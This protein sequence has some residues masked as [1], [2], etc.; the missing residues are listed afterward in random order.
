GVLTVLHNSEGPLPIPSQQVES[1]QRMLGS[2]LVCSLHPY[3]K[4]GD[5]VRVTRGPLCGCRGILCRQDPR[6]GR[7]VVSLNIIRQSVSV[8]LDVDDVEPVGERTDSERFG[9]TP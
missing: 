2:S 8:E 1:I 7:L 4:E 6:K 9:L 3:L 5:W